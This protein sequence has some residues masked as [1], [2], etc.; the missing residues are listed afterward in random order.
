MTKKDEQDLPWDIITRD[1]THGIGDY[2][3]EY[4]LVPKD[5]AR[6]LWELQ[7]KESSKFIQRLFGYHGDNLMQDLK[8]ASYDSI[9]KENERLKKQVEVLREGLEWI[10]RADLVS[11]L[12]QTVDGGGCHTWQKGNEPW[13]VA[14]DTIKKADEIANEGG[15][16]KDIAKEGDQ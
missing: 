10:G 16:D 15:S 11:V 9:L 12:K 6:E 13:I 7:K 4:C 5:Q 14:K 3:V 2:L 8:L 1:E